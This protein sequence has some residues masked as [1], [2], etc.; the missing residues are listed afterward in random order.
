MVIASLLLLRSEAHAWATQYRTSLILI[1]FDKF[2]LAIKKRFAR[3][4][5]TAETISMFFSSTRSSTYTEYLGLLREYTF[6]FHRKCVNAEALIKQ[7]IVRHP[8]YK[9][10]IVKRRIFIKHLRKES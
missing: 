10:V 5:K 8:R 9:I 6:I 1:K 3:G 4:K 2:K 7:V